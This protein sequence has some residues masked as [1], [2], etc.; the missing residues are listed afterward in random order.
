MSPVPGSPENVGT[1]YFLHIWG[2]PSSPGPFISGSSELLFSRPP[3]LTGGPLAA[4]SAED[5]IVSEAATDRAGELSR[6]RLLLTPD[7]PAASCS[8]ASFGHSLAASNRERRQEQLRAAQELVDCLGAGMD[9]LSVEQIKQNK[10]VKLLK[11]SPLVR[12]PFP[13]HVF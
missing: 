4:L 3:P 11:T 13:F 10:E 7:V 2:V 1:P 8:S 12:V 5:T 6:R 9:L